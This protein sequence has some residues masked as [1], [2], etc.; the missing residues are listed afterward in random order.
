[1]NPLET[2]FLT[3]KTIQG[4]AGNLPLRNN[5][6]PW[7]LALTAADFHSIDLS[8]I[9]V[10]SLANRIDTKFCL[11]LAQ[12]EMILSLLKHAYR[13][14]TVQG[15]RLQ[16]Y[17]NLYFDTPD[18]ALYQLHVNKRAHQYKVRIRQYASTQQA[19]LEV[20]HKN[21]QGFTMKTRLPVDS[22]LPFLGSQE[23]SWLA[24][25]LPQPYL[26]LEPKLVNTF[27][28]IV[29]A[30][31]ALQERVT[32]DFNLGFSSG[33]RVE[34]GGCAVI[35]EVKRE[36]RK[37]PSLFLELMHSCHQRPT[38]FSKYGIGV[39]LLYAQVKFNPLKARILWLKRI[40]GGL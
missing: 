36:T 9:E 7:Q 11:S 5:T 6:I 30:D 33:W 18:F 37:Q 35:A 13:M 19:F 21:N 39:A 16:D 17:Q 38:S 15:Y 20:K 4:E 26:N 24:E 3:A 2:E 29:L 14:L 23:R 28:R 40:N 22:S 1:M 27:T 10:V 8:E 32:L 34:R 25:E 31:N 12:I